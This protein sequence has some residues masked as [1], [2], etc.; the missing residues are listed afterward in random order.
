MSNSAR[1]HPHLST[2]R[3]ARPIEPPENGKIPRA[4]PRDRSSE[5]AA[6]S[7]RQ[8]SPRERYS[9]T[10]PENAASAIANKAAVE[11]EMSIHKQSFVARR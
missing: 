3:R 11:G 2:P 9:K 8:E 1:D 5:A 6:G 4:T 7:S 10:S